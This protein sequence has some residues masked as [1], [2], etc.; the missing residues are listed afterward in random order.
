MI[1]HHIRRPV[2]P[3]VPVVSVNEL[4]YICTSADAGR[5]LRHTPEYINRLCLKG[6]LPAYKE[7]NIWLIRRDD[8]LGYIEQKFNLAA[9]KRLN[10][11][12]YR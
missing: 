8:L 1:T 12:E 7:G 3:V 5:L 11:K 6:T 2:R 10:P 4:P 9:Q